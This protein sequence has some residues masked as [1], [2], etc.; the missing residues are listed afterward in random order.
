MISLGGRSA[1]G[2][3]LGFKFQPWKAFEH[4]AQQAL[5]PVEQQVQQAAQQAVTDET[6]DLTEQ[7]QDEA[8]QA[9]QQAGLSGG[10]TAANS[11]Y[12]GPMNEHISLGGRQLGVGGVFRYEGL[13]LPGVDGPGVAG[14]SNLIIAASKK[15]LDA[16]LPQDTENAVLIAVKQET[17][18]AK[19]RQFAATLIPTY[20]AAAGVLY[21]R[22]ITLE[23]GSGTVNG[24]VGVGKFQPFKALKR[25]AQDATKVG[26]VAFIPGAGAA[27][28]LATGA[29]EAGH[30]KAGKKIGTNLA[31][32]KVLST[33]A[34][35]Y[36][37]G[38]MQANPAFFAKTLALG[39]TDEALHGKNVGQAILDQKK[40]V[41]QWLGD[42][43]KYAS[44][45]AGVPP[46]VTPALTGAANLAEGKPLPQ[47][48]LG[49]AGVVVGQAVGPAAQ[50]ALQQGATFGNQLAQ[51][52][53]P[54]VMAQI[55]AA[56]NAL[57]PEATHAFD[58]GL[59]ISTAQKL[60]QKG[61]ASAH[62][63]LPTDGS[64]VGKV[65]TAL[66]ARTND[67]LSAGMKDVQRSLPAN[68]ADLAHEAT[69]K[70]VAQPALSHLSSR[71]L[72][73]HLGI[74]EPVARVA[75]ASMSH[76]VPGAPLMHPHRLEALVGRHRHRP[77][78]PGGPIDQWASYYIQQAPPDMTPPPAAAS[79]EPYPPAGAPG[80]S[81]QLGGHGGGGGRGGH[82]HGGGGHPHG[83]RPHGHGPR[84][85]GGGD[86]RRE[87]ARGYRGGV[88]E[89]GGGDF[90]WYAEEP[91][92]VCVDLSDVYP[93]YVSD[94]PQMPNTT[95]IQP[96]GPSLKSIETPDYLRE[97]VRTLHGR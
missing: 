67:L 97:N 54:Q 78:P 27:A 32:N 89:H 93:G 44:Q 10:E 94:P 64:P 81:D 7:A 58:T 62:A 45:A 39:A 9:L 76:D 43:A 91:P 34:Q 16:N 59:A 37:S 92:P 65:V 69:A 55:A 26:P 56:K 79:Y 15:P 96:T 63:L 72:A 86:Y 77:P 30:T 17:D 18:P 70:L 2:F 75:L 84:E 48:I 50:Q 13:R 5:V 49:A 66:S 87:E 40:A 88:R 28:I 8:Q 36:K 74:Q 95:G 25:I 12:R 11:S 19:L 82:G 52:A 35:T 90:D 3:G 21:A 14:P 1:P 57:P 80:V 68:A 33:L 41:T 53:T 71:D 31:K 42:K 73:R 85:H 60:Q 20:P 29:V 4:Q 61:Y 24:D 83:G 47:D 23:G 46:E 6:V 38:Y 22:A 51:A